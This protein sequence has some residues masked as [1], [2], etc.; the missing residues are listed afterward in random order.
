VETN[1]TPA[2]ALHARQTRL[3]RLGLISLVMFVA[4]VD[5]VV[6]YTSYTLTPREAQVAGLQRVAEADERLT[7][8]LAQAT[9]RRVADRPSRAAAAAA[10][11]RLRAAFAADTE[12]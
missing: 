1:G 12:A 4:G 6:L 9:S 7:S 2:R 8:L 11:D 3:R 10:S 5:A